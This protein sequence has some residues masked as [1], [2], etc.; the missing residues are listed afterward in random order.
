MFPC[1]T[2]LADVHV[3]EQLVFTFGFLLNLREGGKLAVDLL[4][5]SLNNVNNDGKNTVYF[6]LDFWFYF[7]ILLKGGGYNYS[8][9]NIGT[10]ASAYQAT[11]IVQCVLPCCLWQ[12]QVFLKWKT[13]PLC[14]NPLAICG[15]LIKLVP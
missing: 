1:I 11:P 2:S 13:I 5:G 12:D 10:N 7:A 4:L 6:R 8:E 3:V 14:G 9:G 15:F